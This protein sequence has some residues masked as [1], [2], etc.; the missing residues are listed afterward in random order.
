MKYHRLTQ[1]QFH[2]MHE[3]F[4]V[5]LTTNGIDKVKWDHIKQN[6]SSSVS[7]FLDDFS[8]LVWEKIIQKCSYLDFIT[9]D[10]LFLFHAGKVNVDVIVVK[11][12]SKSCDLLTKKGFQWMLDNI[13][14]D[15][16]I[17]YRDSKIYEKSRNEFIYSNL[18]KGALLSKGIQY[19]GLKSY[20]PNSIK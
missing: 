13:K 7:T 16:V 20:F 6:N 3:E 9:N 12:N 2:E 8:D 1:E 10:K 18:L 4:S 11:V 19:E 15:Y 5:F 17:L 14:T